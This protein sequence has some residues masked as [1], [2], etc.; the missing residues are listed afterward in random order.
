MAV[1]ILE[2]LYEPNEVYLKAGV[3]VT[4]LLPQDQKQLHLFEDENPKHLKLME[5]MDA[6]HRKTGER[7]IRLGSQDLQKTW[8]MKQQHLSPNYTTNIKEIMEVVC[9]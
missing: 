2:K 3:I 6:Y 9:R 1:T 7:K 5:V 8:K 4:Q